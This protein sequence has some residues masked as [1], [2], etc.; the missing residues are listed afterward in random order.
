M[1]HSLDKDRILHLNYSEK[2]IESLAIVRKRI[3]VSVLDQGSECG[4]CT[5]VFLTMASC[6]I[7]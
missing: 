2:D 4:S 6:G 5:L 1:S 3:G 7:D